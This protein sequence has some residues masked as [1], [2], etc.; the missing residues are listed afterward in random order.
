VAQDSD[1]EWLLNV[2]RKLYTRSWE[3]PDYV[4]RKLWGLVT[5]PRN[6]RCSLE[7]VARNKGSRT[8]GVDGV[9]VRMILGTHS[10]SSSGLSFVRVN[11]SPARC[12][13]KGARRVRRRGPRRPLGESPVWRRGSY[14]YRPQFG[15]SP[16]RPQFSLCRQDSKIV[17]HLPRCGE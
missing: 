14:S 10:S 5:D 15:P 3:N 7:R 11:S 16:V 6:L 13:A 2:Q 17:L 4:F 12:I 9:T 8:A 1:K